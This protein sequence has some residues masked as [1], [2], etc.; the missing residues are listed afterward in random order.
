MD[1]IAPNRGIPS[2]ASPRVQD[3]LVGPSMVNQ[4]WI[5]FLEFTNNIGKIQM[6]EYD[7]GWEFLNEVLKELSKHYGQENTRIVVS[8][9]NYG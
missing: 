2:D 6:D 8:F 3:E 5:S 1:S 7:W 4:T 9:D